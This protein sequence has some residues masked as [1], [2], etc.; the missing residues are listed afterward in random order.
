MNDNTISKPGPPTKR[1]LIASGVLRGRQL[2]VFRAL[3]ELELVRCVDGSVHLVQASEAPRLRMAVAL[4]H[5][6]RV[7][8]GAKER[9]A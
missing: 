1:T 2:V 7:Q 9:V 4:K 8:R 3:E 5:L 6:T